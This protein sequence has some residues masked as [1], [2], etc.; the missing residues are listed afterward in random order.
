[1]TQTESLIPRLRVERLR[2]K[3]TQQ[4]VSRRANVWQATLS[5]LETGTL[6]LKAASPVMKRLA[7]LYGVPAE[8]LLRPVP[9]KSVSG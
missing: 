1:M 6:R 5:T 8:D 7:R 4:D 3:W 9:S 2:R